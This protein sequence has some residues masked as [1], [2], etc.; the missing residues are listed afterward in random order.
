NGRARRDAASGGGGAR[1]L[2][3]RAEHVEGP[4]RHGLGAGIPRGEALVEPGPQRRL[5]GLALLGRVARASLQLAPRAASDQS[6]D[7]GVGVW[8]RLHAPTL[9]HVPGQPAG[10][11]PSPRISRKKHRATPVHTPAPGGSAVHG[12]AGPDPVRSCRGSA[13]G[14]PGERRSRPSA[15]GGATRA[16]RGRRRSG[17]PGGGSGGRRANPRSRRPGS[18]AASSAR[19]SPSRAP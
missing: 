6:L 15:V 16:S 17:A 7:D 14:V 11:P 18:E 13:A 8:R 3:G 4:L 5:D 10:G 1:R 19:S 9:F 2:G 12:G